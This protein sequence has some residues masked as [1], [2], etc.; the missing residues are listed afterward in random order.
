MS[1]AISLIITLFY[2]VRGA[3]ASVYLPII[4]LISL[5]FLPRAIG[6]GVG[7]EGFALTAKRLI[8]LATIAYMLASVGR[9]KFKMNASQFRYL[10]FPTLL[11]IFLTQINPITSGNYLYSLSVGIEKVVEVVV[12]IFLANIL[13]NTGDARVSFTKFAFYYPAIA[14]FPLVLV[15]YFFLKQP[16]LG[17]VIGLEQLS[18]EGSEGSL[19]ARAR[20]G[21][22]RAQGLHN[23]PIQLG[24]YA[25]FALPFIYFLH[26]Q[27]ALKFLPFI[28][29]MGVLF[30]LALL[31]GSRGAAMLAACSI[32]LSPLL[33]LRLSRPFVLIGVLV[34]A[35][36]GAILTIESLQEFQLLRF[37]TMSSASERSSYAR[38]YQF[39]Y[40]MP[41]ILENPLFGHGFIRH[42]GREFG[43]S[44]FD[45]FFLGLLLESGIV[46]AVIFYIPLIALG[47]HLF[48]GA[49]RASQGSTQRNF[50]IASLVFLS[51]FFVGQFIYSVPDNHIYFTFL[52]AIIFSRKYLARS[53]L[54]VAGIVGALKAGRAS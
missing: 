24:Q 50:C 53:D 17:L 14:I 15:E 25:A 18:I 39:N 32:V 2:I 30:L 7:E 52:A 28:S 20:D 47:T 46:G 31:S 27:K 11:Y 33:A 13:T 3:K 12:C 54:E 8:Y 5:P 10:L 36:F 21:V 42:I 26:L 40:Y 23:G 48:M 51:M 43:I 45:I 1:G 34:V 6:F 41:Y 22:Y 44:H 19:M 4:F 49:V 16:T 29:V 9:R 38:L 37:D 35:G